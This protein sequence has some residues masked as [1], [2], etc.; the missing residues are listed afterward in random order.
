MIVFVEGDVAS[1]KSTCLELLSEQYH[2]FTE[3]V[4]MWSQHLFGVYGPD[5]ADWALPMQMLA[6]TTRQELLLRAKDA[7]DV[8]VV[9]RSTRSDGLFAQDLTG[10]DLEAYNVVR[11]RYDKLL[12]GLDAVHVYLRADPEVCM[13]R[14]AVRGRPQEKGMG[15]QRARTMHERHEL[16]FADAFIVDANR[17]KHA[18]L[19][20]VA[21]FIE[22]ESAK[23][24]C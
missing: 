11:R 4:E 3:P 9:E 10:S 14:I 5:F 16:E 22:E 17:D 7:G 6:L 12:A 1:G 8:V 15:L 13:E 18:V 2:V 23:R 24:A 19:K 21:A 20:D